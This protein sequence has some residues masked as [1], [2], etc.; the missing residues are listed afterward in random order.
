LTR[1]KEKSFAA[2]VLAALFV[3][4]CGGGGGDSG[5]LTPSSQGSYDLQTAMVALIESGQSNPIELS[6]T[7]IVGGISY[8]FSGTGT[9]T[10]APGASGTFNG[11]TA[12]LQSQSI[13]G[14]ISVAGQKE[15]YSS[16]VVNAYE[17]TSGAILGQ[18]ES[19]EFDVAQS[20]ISIPTTVG[21]TSM[22]L[23]TLSRYSD[24]T[25]SV[26]LGTVQV[27]VA[28][29]AVPANA[30][31]PELVQFTYKIFD[32]NQVLVE[33]DT[34]SYSLTEDNVLALNSAAAQS[35][36]GTVSITPVPP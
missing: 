12:L 8:A 14:T 2:A 30:G 19:N 28:V 4:A 13:S 34:F 3:S 29:T 16:T 9:S 18:S 31:G 27:S 21:T 22:M 32:T 15:A 33:T 1:A 10:L 23:G 5:N 26:A 6:G 11:T 24:S 17:P 36:S 7:A 20:P 25:L 35:A